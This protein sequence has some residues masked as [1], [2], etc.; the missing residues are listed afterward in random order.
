M[1][2]VCFLITFLFLVFNTSLL[3]AQSNAGKCRLEITKF[4]IGINA[5][6]YRGRTPETDGFFDQGIAGFGQLYFPFQVAVDYSN[7]FS[8]SI[9][10]KNEYNNRIFLIRPSALLHVVDNGSY[11]FGLSLQFSWLITHQ[12]YL[13]YQIS[14]IYMEAPK[15]AAPDLYSGF[16][17][18]HFISISKPLSRH[19]TLTAGIVH[20]SGAHLGDGKISNQD[21]LSLGI[22][23]NL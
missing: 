9:A 6:P 10:I 15:N 17:L 2:V 20:F 5:G 22:K 19:F 23:Y 3:K 16:N 7:H 12:F 4:N 11:A 8:D 18:H 1:K 14:G 21:L 13:E